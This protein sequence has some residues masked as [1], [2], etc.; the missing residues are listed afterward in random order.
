MPRIVFGLLGII[1][2]VAACAQTGSVSISAV[3]SCARSGGVWRPVLEVC[4]T[5][6]GGGGY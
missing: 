4:E 6:A 3:E 5:S 2:L 1:V